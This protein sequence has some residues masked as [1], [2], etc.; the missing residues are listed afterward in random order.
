MVLYAQVSRD[1]IE[2]AKGLAL[3]LIGLALEKAKEGLLRDILGQ[4]PAVQF[5]IAVARDFVILLLEVDRQGHV[6]PFPL[7]ND[8]D[9]A[10]VRAV[11]NFFFFQVLEVFPV[12]EHQKRIAIYSRKSKFTGKGESISNQIDLCRD[13]ISAHYGASALARA[14][15]YEDEG[16]SGKTLERPGFQAMMQAA[17]AREL[18]ADAP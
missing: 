9:P 4:S 17:R 15:V 2:I 6:P 14:I 12:Q 1:D 8:F 10:D 11:F 3:V 5:E 7:Y 18:S 16:F 13:H